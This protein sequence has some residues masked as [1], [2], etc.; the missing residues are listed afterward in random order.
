MGW[1]YEID[2]ANSILSGDYSDLEDENG[3]IIAQGKDSMYDYEDFYMTSGSP[4]RYKTLE[5]LMKDITG[6][7]RELKLYADNRNNSE[8]VSGGLTVFSPVFYRGEWWLE[9]ES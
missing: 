7:S 3:E 4:F 9:A 1:F 5:S 2:I 8:D 6:D